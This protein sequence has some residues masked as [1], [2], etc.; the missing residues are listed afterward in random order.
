[1]AQLRKN[2]L[3]NFAGQ[4]WAALMQ[5]IFIP[6]YIKYLGIEAYGLIGF[7]AMLQGVLQILD[8]GLSPTMTRELA[9]FSAMPERSLESRNFVRTLE[10]IYWGIGI[11]IG[12]IIYAASP[13][14][15]Y[16]WINASSL[17][18]P[19]LLKSVRLIGLIAALQWPLSFYQGGLMGLQRLVL[20]NSIKIGNSTVF[21]VGATLVL[22]FVS[23][24]IVSFFTWQACVSALQVGVVTVCLWKNLPRSDVSPRF[25]KKIF[26][27]IRGFAT[28]MTG[29]MISGIVVTQ[30]DKLILSKL[31][32]LRFFGYYSLAYVVSN[33]LYLAI[34]PVFNALFPRYSALA[35]TKDNHE[36][37]RL[38]HLGSQFTATLLL[39]LAAI[40]ALFPNDVL[41]LWTGNA[42]TA[43]NASGI[44]ALLV[45]GTA[46][47]GLMY[48][49]TALQLSYGWTG[50]GLRIN[51][52]FVALIIPGIIVMATMYGA[53]GA[54]SVW[55]FLNILYVIIAVPLTHRRILQGEAR[56][57]FVQ[58]VGIVFLCVL[59]ISGI[60]R[61]LVT[62]PLHSVGGAFVLAGI[63]LL[64]I[65]AAVFA[66]PQLRRIALDNIYR[67]IPQ[68]A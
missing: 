22:A 21:G 20:L 35:A 37:S 1:M 49:V 45:I 40:L 52:A 7:Y 3:A 46:L 17:D 18:S 6:F 43:Q 29:I 34:L 36:L 11:L 38:Y 53:V 56:Q 33:G 23:A 61:F 44:V 62:M 51:L 10:T 54:A 57:W 48:P 28:G 47:N 5:I 27:D 19:T 26:K 31:L 41:M 68:R 39:P 67:R 25:D 50:I 65:L 15:V 4:G 9:R 55:A 14:I 60:A 8:F 42:E 63:L 64:L 16:H 66:A 24:D 13:V 58:D 32:S 59:V 30:I 12:L 2:I